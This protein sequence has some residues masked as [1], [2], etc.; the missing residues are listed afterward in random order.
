MNSKTLGYISIIMAL[1]ISLCANAEVRLDKNG[2]APKLIVDGQPMLVIGGELG[3]STATCPEDIERIFPKLKRME[4]NTILVPAYWDL[5][6]PEEGRFDFSLTNAVIDEARKNDLKVIFLWFGVWK[7][8]MSCYTP[9]WFKADYKRFPRAKT[10]EGKPLEIA[11]AFSENV[12]KAESTVFTRWLDHLLDYDK[13][14]TVIGIQIENEIGMLED[15]RD[16]SSLA[17]ALFVKG[18]PVELASYIKKNKASLHPYIK[19]RIEGKEVFA[20][21]SW[22]SIFGNN[23]YTDEIFM[24]WNY[25]KYV[26]RLAQLARKKT[27]IPL[28]VNAAMDSR[29]RQPGEYPSAGPL[30]KLIDI[31]HA[32][33]PDIDFISPD[34]YDSGFTDWVRQY[35]LPG[36]ILFIP[37]I[38]QSTTANAPQ[39]YY[40]IGEHNA[41]GLSPFCIENGEDSPESH[42]VKGRKLLKEI[43][44]ILL[45]NQGKGTMNGLYFDAD[46]TERVIMKDGL[47]IRARHYFTLPWDSRS[48]DGSKWPET[49]GTIIRLESM[50]YLIAGTGLVIDFEDAADASG[51]RQE[52]GEDGFAQ[53]GKRVDPNKIANAGKK[54]TGRRIGI[55]SVTEMK[56][57]AN[58]SL[59]PLR[60]HGGDETHQGRHVRI[61]P[62]DY[63]VLLVSLY[64][65]M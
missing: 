7:N 13:H 14:S 62:D 25:A 27:D 30:A 47:K 44:P 50:K 40:A 35:A 41:I 54:W 38:R 16:H 52:L 45:S 36:N 56:V 58:G 22:L 29:G 8:S 2:V 4:L 57:S 28:Y 49:G 17:D 43:A 31:W 11:S 18:I 9:E 51:A 24:A 64:E 6:E 5:M 39:A 15:A 21:A 61:S 59:V 12:Y 32:A 33:A 37:E 3:N 63:K 23:I 53:T 34:L 55:K 48:R 42:S 10:K 65:Y 60:Y 46:S 1:V 26:Q 19:E 20:G